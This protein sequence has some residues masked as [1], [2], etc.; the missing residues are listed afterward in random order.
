MPLSW[1]SSLL[2][3]F[4][5]SGNPPPHPCRSYASCQ[6]NLPK[7]VLVMSYPWSKTFDGSPFAIALISTLTIY[8]LRKKTFW[9]NLLIYVCLYIHNIKKINTS[10]I[11]FSH[12]KRLYCGLPEVYF[13]LPFR[14]RRVQ[15]TAQTCRPGQVLIFLPS[16]VFSSLL[17]RSALLPN[18]H[19]S[20][21]EQA[22]MFLTHPTVVSLWV[23]PHIYNPT[24]CNI[25]KVHIRHCYVPGLSNLG[26]GVF[27]RWFLVTQ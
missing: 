20:F 5:P 14:D 15:D 17:F 8:T 4:L 22:F 16:L 10:S 1:W 24:P 27:K 2:P 18:S 19:V 26:S 12:P 9:G 3:V 21:F 7:S 13:L 25:I 23:Y 6:V 11:F